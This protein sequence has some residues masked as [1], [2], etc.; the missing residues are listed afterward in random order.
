MW[1][2][3]DGSN[4]PEIALSMRAHDRVGRRRTDEQWLAETWADPS[5]RVLLL[6]RGKFPVA[7]GGTSAAWVAP[8]DAPDGQRLFLGEQSGVAHFAVLLDKPLDESWA[9][10]RM[11]GQRLSREQAS[12]LVHA[13]ALGEWHRAH[14]FC[15]RCGSPLTVADAGHVLTCSGCGRQQFPR[16]DPAVIMLVTDDQDRALLGRQ[17]KWPDG[18]YSTLAG[19][20]DPGESLEDAVRREVAEEVGVEIG[21]V[22]YLGNQPWPFPA[23]L[24]VGFFATALTTEIRVDEDEISDARWFTREEMRAEAEAGTLL[25]P[26]AISISRTLIETWHGGPLPG[27]W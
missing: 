2:D 15:P 20:V 19:F 4:V 21:Q 17:P 16:T 12:L 5:T 18:R 13:V 23:S 11:V 1:Q 25:L 6:A 7:D 14:R 9:D 24:M 22:T 10:L 3:E 26:G 27:H 8:A